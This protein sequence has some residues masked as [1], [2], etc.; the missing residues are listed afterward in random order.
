[1]KVVLCLVTQLC[2]ILCDTMNCSPPGS[3]VHGIPQAGILELVVIPLSRGSS[4]PRDQTRVSCIA[5]RFF[6]ES[7]GTS[8]NLRN[9]ISLLAHSPAWPFLPQQC[10]R[11]L[12]TQASY[13]LGPSI[14]CSQVSGLRKNYLPDIL[15]F[16]GT[17]LSTS[18]PLCLCLCCYF[19]LKY[20]LPNSPSGKI[21]CIFQIH[22]KCQPSLRSFSPA[23]LLHHHQ[24]ILLC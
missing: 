23:P 14:D 21:I 12:G 16:S 24:L 15:S 9:R 17:V 11:A 4:W 7:P 18:M 20:P 13:L 22:L 19:C 5:G 1:M 8:R 2:P 3:S 6:T 10:H